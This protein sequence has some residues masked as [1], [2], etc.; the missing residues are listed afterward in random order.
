MLVGRRAS[1]AWGLQAPQVWSGLWESPRG[2][3]APPHHAYEAL[4]GNISR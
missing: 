1:A 4:P 2:A 3:G